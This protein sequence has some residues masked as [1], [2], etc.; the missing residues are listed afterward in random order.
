MALKSGSSLQQKRRSTEA[1]ALQAAK[2]DFAL[3]LVALMDRKE[4]SRS[5]LAARLGVPASQVT[6]A[7][8]G[9][10][11]LT[12]NSM[13]K[14][15]RQVGGRVCIR[16]ME[17]ASQHRWLEVIKSPRVAV[18]S[19]WSHSAPPATAATSTSIANAHEAKGHETEP[20]AA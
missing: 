7:L 17:D 13:V 15:V 11:N 3:D 12:I 2:L 18:P 14:M 8:R 1:Y 20:L 16:V 6:K 5:E 9:D 19:A 4:V 10:A